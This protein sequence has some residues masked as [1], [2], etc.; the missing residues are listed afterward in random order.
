MSGITPARRMGQ[1]ASIRS[2]AV[3]YLVPAQARSPPA[4]GSLLPGG[5]C[6]CVGIDRGEAATGRSGLPRCR[7]SRGEVWFRA[8]VGGCAR[9]AGRSRRRCGVEDPAA[10]TIHTCVSEATGDAVGG[11][12]ANTVTT[13]PHPRRVSLTS[14][15]GEL[16]SRGPISLGEAVTNEPAVDVVGA[17][18]RPCSSASRLRGATA[19]SP[20]SRRPPFRPNDGPARTA[21]TIRPSTHS[22]LSSKHDPVHAFTCRSTGRPG[23]FPCRGGRWRQPESTPLAGRFGGRSRQP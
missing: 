11:A 2:W 5:L 7:P 20:S 18:R 15:T 23:S 17:Q 4:A 3:A 22:A 8:L 9:C 1:T 6:S 21:P 13:L 12:A 10:G 19:S 14:A 16:S